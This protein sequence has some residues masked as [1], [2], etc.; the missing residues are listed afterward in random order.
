MRPCIF[1]AFR[2]I[3][4]KAW[5]HTRASTQT[6]GQRTVNE[7]GGVPLLP[8]PNTAT[9][10]HLSLLLYVQPCAKG[11]R[12]V[13]KLNKSRWDHHT[14]NKGRSENREVVGQRTVTLTLLYSLCLTDAC[15][16]TGEVTDYKC[17]EGKKNKFQRRLG[18]LF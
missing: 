10:L 2:Q 5:E 14:L 9:P 12:Q 13:S 7:Q 17:M 18:A 3:H 6:P 1:Q 11:S 15:L 4:T 8:S 16:C